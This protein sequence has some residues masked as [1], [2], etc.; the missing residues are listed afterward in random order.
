MSAWGWAAWWLLWLTTVLIGYALTV[1]RRR[2]DR[3]EAALACDCG[4]YP[5]RL[6]VDLCADHDG[7]HHCRARCRPLH[8]EVQP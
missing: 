8:E 6:Y 1:E 7:W 2:A 5:V 4:L 3:A